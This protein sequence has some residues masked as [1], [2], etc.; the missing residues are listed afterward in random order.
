MADQG[1]GEIPLAPWMPGVAGEQAEELA[2]HLV[3]EHADVLAVVRTRAE[4]VDAHVAEHFAPGG[5]RN[6]E[7]TSLN[8]DQEKIEKA[9]EEAGEDA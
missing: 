3:S 8:F 9:L 5:I 1:E 6:H 7:W 4:N 2:M